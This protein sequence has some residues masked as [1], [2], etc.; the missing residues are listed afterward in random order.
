MTKKEKLCAFIDSSTYVPMTQKELAMVLDIKKQDQAELSRVLDQLIAEGCIM[1]TRKNRFISTK[2]MHIYPGVYLGNERK[3]G[4]AQVQEGEDI[5]ISGAMTGGAMHGD[6]VLVKILSKQ[7]GNRREG[8][9]IKILQHAN[10]DVVGI[11]QKQ[12][13]RLYLQCDNAK[14]W[15][16]IVIQKGSENGA[17]AGQK[18]IV[19]ITVYP[20]GEENA[21]GEVAQVLG[22]PEDPHVQHMSVVRGHDLPQEFDKMVLNEADKAASMPFSM[23]GR[24]DLRDKTII[25]IDGADALDLD[26]AVYVEKNA[27]GNRVLYVSIADV[28]HY[29][30]EGGKVE[31]EAFA[32]GTS[33]YLEGGVIPML[34]KVLSNGICSLNPNQDRLC[35]TCEM[36]LDNTGNVI[37]YNIYESVIHSKYRMT[38]DRVNAILEGDKSL[39]KEYKQIVPMLWDMQSLAKI[40]KE[41]RLAGGSIDFH[42]TETKI[43]Y[44]DKGNPVNIRPFRSGVSENI[45]EEFMLCANKTVA[46]HYTHLDVPFVYRVHEAPSREKLDNLQQILNVFCIKLK[47]NK[48]DIQPKVLGEILE[49]IKDQPYEKMVSTMML[50]SM[51]KA[52]YDVRNLGHFGLAAKDYCHFTS[53]IRRLSDLAVHRMIKAAPHLNQK[54]YDHYKTYTQTA[55]KN[56][57]DREIV[58][59]EA[60]RESEK[61]QIAVYMNRFIGEKFTGVISMVMPFGFFVELENSVE[62]CIRVN[63]LLD[64]Y[65]TYD[66][67]RYT[68]IGE[69]TKRTFEIGQTVQVQLVSCNIISG[70]ID[71]ILQ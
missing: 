22:R 52:A 54:K 41:K 66:Q 4:F 16:K 71:F 17:K 31:R 47:G 7:N 34:P 46:A 29:V 45:I 10:T 53:P 43:D 2:G 27:T 20:R 69:R 37:H 35:I 70:E 26:D 1:Q 55:A 3:I 67:S 13:R 24:K 44:D 48:D 51:M 9:V 58:A 63:H 19:H 68:L 62:G 57:S 6:Q 12:G 15:Q 64:D 30:K 8:E 23:E 5:Y 60:E 40:L 38:Y 59:M 32:R 25:T 11:V 33:V 50:R 28:A 18:A 36:E 42:F 56:A 61:V 14:L 49:K 65:Y 39:Q 21:L